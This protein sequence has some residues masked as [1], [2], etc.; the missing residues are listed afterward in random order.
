MRREGD[1]VVH[2]IDQKLEAFALLQQPQ[3][4][5]V[6]ARPGL[7][8]VDR[9][10][11]L[12]FQRR[13]ELAWQVEELFRALE[14]QRHQPSFNA[15]RVDVRRVRLGQRVA[16]HVFKRPEL[17]QIRLCPSGA[18]DD[19]D[20]SDRLEARLRVG[21]FAPR[22][23]APL[24]HGHHAFQPRLDRLPGVFD[25]GDYELDKE[26]LAPAAPRVLAGLEE[27]DAHRDVHHHEP[28]VEPHRV[29]AHC[30]RRRTRLPQPVAK[31]PPDRIL[32]PHRL[33]GRL[34]VVG[35]R[36]RLEPCRG[37]EARPAPDADS[38]ERDDVGA[39]IG[40][41][42]IGDGEGDGEE[43]SGAGL[44]VGFVLDLVDAERDVV[45]EGVVDVAVR[46]HREEVGALQPHEHLL[47]VRVQDPAARRPQRGHAD[48]HLH[49]VLHARQPL[50]HARATPQLHLIQPQPLSSTCDSGIPD[51]MPDT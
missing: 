42:I 49:V 47:H 2:G 41:E 37:G 9:H 44:G 34:G 7:H 45:E 39:G 13:R 26:H 4:R 8:D 15:P 14:N 18:D 17:R 31:R 25:G 11:V 32:L 30:H 22:V 12:Q 50:Y 35:A 20:I 38:A 5:V 33:L 28:L 1:T 6:H 24:H 40:G 23:H 16:R 3:H 10:H 29:L 43:L 48:K 27:R 51:S 21:V 46:G 36:A 19:V